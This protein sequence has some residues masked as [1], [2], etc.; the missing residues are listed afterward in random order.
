MTVASETDP[1]WHI[2]ERRRGKCVGDERSEGY[3]LRYI[4]PA[5]RAVG[6]RY[7]IVV[8]GDGGYDVTEKRGYSMAP[9]VNRWPMS[10]H[11]GQT[12]CHLPR[13]SL[14]MQIGLPPLPTPYLIVPRPSSYET[15][16]LRDASLLPSSPVNSATKLLHCPSPS[17]QTPHTNPLIFISFFLPMFHSQRFAFSPALTEKCAMEINYKLRELARENLLPNTLSLFLTTFLSF[18]IPCRKIR[19]GR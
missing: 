2:Y 3:R 19:S 6:S 9:G 1:K 12:L 11:R 5:M 4:L 14:R 18:F 16:R 13:P 17:D 7:W 15:S 10:L 8:A